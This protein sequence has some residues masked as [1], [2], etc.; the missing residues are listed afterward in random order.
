MEV[1]QLSTGRASVNK[2]PL[3]LTGGSEKLAV[4]ES[5][6]WIEVTFPKGVTPV[7]AQFFSQKYVECRPFNAYTVGSQFEDGHIELYNP[8][9]P[10]MG[11]HHIWNGSALRDSGVDRLQVLKHYTNNS[12]RV[13]RLDLAV[14][15]FNG[16]FTPRQV[17]RKIR[18]HEVKTKAKKFRVATDAE[19]PGYTQYVGH[20]TSEVRLRIYDKAAEQGFE[21][22]WVRIEAQLRSKRG[23]S[24]AMACLAGTNYR[25]IV[26][27]IFDIPDWPPWVAAFTTD[28]ITIKAIRKDS[29]TRQWLLKQ[30]APALAKELVLHGDSFLNQF[31][32]AVLIK[33]LELGGAPIV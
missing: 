1:V 33:R 11:V 2:T 23:H 14:D 32:D 4:G 9:R 26:R 20:E 7:N 31:I 6:D 29:N 16:G 12:A 27:G 8:S 17:T 18:R 19:A 25:S 13:T 28:P 3:L 30:A 24:A 22:R 5:I 21:G 15:I 10:E